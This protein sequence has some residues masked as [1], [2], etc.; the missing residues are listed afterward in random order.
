[1][2]RTSPAQPSVSPTADRRQKHEED[3]RQTT[4]TFSD[5]AGRIF[6]VRNTPPTFRLPNS[7]FADPNPQDNQS[8]HDTLCP[9]FPSRSAPEIPFVIHTIPLDDLLLSRIAVNPAS[10]KPTEYSNGW[11]LA[12]DVRD[13]WRRLEKTLH[14]VSDLLLLFVQSE[15]HCDDSIYRVLQERGHWSAPG[16]YGYHRIHPLYPTAA[17]A[18]RRAHLALTL[19]AARVS[20]AVAVWLHSEGQPDSVPG[21]ITFLAN[22]RVPSSLIDTLQQSVITRFNFGLRVGVVMDGSD[23]GWTPFVSVLDYARVP[24]F[25]LWKTPEHVDWFSSQYPALRHLIPAPGSGHMAYNQ[26]PTT[27]S[28]PL[29][30][31]ISEFDIRL[32]PDTSLA[33]SRT[34][35]G[36]H[37]RPEE[38][39]E[40][41][42]RRRHAMEHTLRQRETAAALERRQ[43]RLAYSKSTAVPGPRC[44]V[45]V[46]TSVKYVYPDAPFKWLDSP[47]RLGIKTSAVRGLW[48][49]HPP[50]LRSYN[51][52]FD[53]WDLWLPDEQWQNVDGTSSAII[54]SAAPVPQLR[55][56]A[57]IQQLP[58][59]PPPP[60]TAD[61]E[62]EL[63]DIPHTSSSKPVMS[64]DIESAIKEELH[65]LYPAFTNSSEE[66]VEVGFSWEYITLWF[67][68]HAVP[69]STPDVDYTTYAARPWSHFAEQQECMPS[70]A[71][72]VRTLCGWIWAVRERKWNSA[73]LGDVWDL[74][75]HSTQI[76]PLLTHLQQHIRVTIARKRQEDLPAAFLVHYLQDLPQAWTLAVDALALVFLARHHHITDSSSAANL[77]L[78]RGIQFHTVIQRPPSLNPRTLPPL[79]PAPRH[80]RRHDHIPTPSEY[81]EYMTHVL[82]LL[83]HPHVVRAAM[84]TGGIVWRIMLEAI[85]REDDLY[86]MYLQLGAAGPTG[87]S[88]KHAVV[89]SMS[90]GASAEDDTL[91]EEERDIICGV[92]KVYTGNG[93]QTEDRSW[94]PKDTQW[95]TGMGYNGIWTPYQEKWFTMRLRK[96]FKGE[97]GPRNGKDWKND[98]RGWK[99]PSKLIAPLL[100]SAEVFVSFTA[101]NFIGYQPCGQ[102]ITARLARGLL[103][104]SYAHASS[105]LHSP[106]R[107]CTTAELSACDP[108]A[109]LARGPA[110]ATAASALSPSPLRSLSLALTASLATAHSSPH[111]HLLRPLLD[112][113][114]ASGMNFV[115]FRHQFQIPVTQ[116]EAWDHFDGTSALPVPAA[117]NAPTVIEIASIAAWDKKENLAMYL[118]NIKIARLGCHH[119]GQAQGQRRRHL[120]EH[121]LKDAREDPSPACQPASRL[122]QYVDRLR[123][124]YETL[125]MLEVN[126]SDAEYASTVIAFLPPHLS[127]FIAQ[128]SAQTRAQTLMLPT[129]A[130]PTAPA[131]PDKPPLDPEVMLTL[132]L[133]EWNR[134]Q[135]QCQ[136]SKVK[137]HDTGPAASV[138]STQKPNIR[139]RGP[140]KPVGVCLSSDASTPQDQKPPPPAAQF[141]NTPARSPAAY[142]LYDIAG[143]WSAFL[144]RLSNFDLSENDASVGQDLWSLDAASA[145]SDL[146]EDSDA[147]HSLSDLDSLPAS[148]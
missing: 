132:V 144:P 1:M 101:P 130:T 98:L 11:G 138:L 9:R 133:E 141:G 42:F 54:Q 53:E 47:Y 143:A 125:I 39:R 90:N 43:I 91:S 35:S 99:Q 131:D 24:I 3:W 19:L 37:Q 110:R 75:I 114:D 44:H 95:K 46:W 140:R 123:I 120:I 106:A 100:E 86:Y 40:A 76:I 52:F 29:F 41:F 109:L 105:A 121:L 18:I 60:P 145:Y 124:A 115:L 4:Y 30:S 58:L 56:T 119:Q 102:A 62:M 146:T 32:H 135:A 33:S 78:R 61:Y 79:A 26:P 65:S 107:A 49:V 64:K 10:M 142:T 72:L 87:D 139:G 136:T 8:Y 96:I 122:Q 7:D 81:G 83:H 25:V 85:G 137:D 94:W 12:G 31:L 55:P 97:A 73:I 45:Y 17:F 14:F 129:T 82:D 104:R 117:P 69:T 128:L 92:Y 126:I 67:G 71:P 74:D 147:T 48:L 127:A 148:S 77:L 84:L 70:E 59:P 116:K 134:R 112:K 88:R 118:I 13:S 22:Q 28:P 36:P 103:A 108:A 68:V 57:V 2:S 23:V 38:T 21:W 80:Y 111:S 50:K 20:L 51:P 93:L 5:A 34:P 66:E 113:L 16:D 15:G 27:S 6:T 89:Y 63:Y